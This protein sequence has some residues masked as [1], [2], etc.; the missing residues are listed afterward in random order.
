MLSAEDEVDGHHAVSVG[1]ID[2]EKLFYLMSRGLDRVE[3]EKLIVEAM[4]NPVLDR[5]EDTV[6]RDE[7][8]ETIQRRLSGVK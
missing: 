4:F 5:L 8:Y 2:E 3:A 7:I 1:R 6:L